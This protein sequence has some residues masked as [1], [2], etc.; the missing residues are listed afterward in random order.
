MSTAAKTLALMLLLAGTA[1]AAEQ[2]L[3]VDPT[4]PQSQSV[5]VL[6]ANELVVVSNPDTAQQREHRYERF[7]LLDTPSY[8]LTTEKRAIDTSV[9]PSIR[10]P[11]L[12]DDRIREV[13]T[14]AT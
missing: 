11:S 7:P 12:A 6:S 9:G 5:V 4:N 3:L 2:F 14:A 8:W 1:P 10:G 13:G